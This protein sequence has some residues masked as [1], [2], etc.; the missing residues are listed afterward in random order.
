MKSIKPGRGPSAM[1]AVGSIFAGAFGVFW[2]IA[3]VR[4]G[5]PIHF[6]FFC[7]IFIVLAIVQGVYNYKNATGKNRM[8]VYDTTDSEEESDP[9]NRFVKK[10]PKAKSEEMQNG[11]KRE[12]KFCPF[13]GSPV[14]K[15]H[16][17]C[18]ECGKKYK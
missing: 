7:V 10:E 15:A 9:F 11:E 18:S 2:T 13:C 14:Q 16:K 1:G 6:S 8:S 3:T 17:F 4:M 12:Y 5:A